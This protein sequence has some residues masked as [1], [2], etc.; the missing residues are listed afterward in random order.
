MLIKQ[1][2]DDLAKIK[3]KNMWIE[4]KIMTG[5]VTLTVLVVGTLATTVI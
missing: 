2:A 5:R 3:T 1:S 4:R